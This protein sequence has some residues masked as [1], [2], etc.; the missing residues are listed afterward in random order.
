MAKQTQ[1]EVL[2]KQNGRWEI[3][4]QYA[5]SEED[6]AIMEAKSL[7]GLK[8]VEDVKVIR[9]FFDSNEGTS[10]EYNVY[11]PGKKKYRPPHKFPK[12]SLKNKKNS[13][14]KIFFE[15]KRK[16]RSLHY[17]LMNI[18]VICICSVFIVAT[19]SWFVSRHIVETFESILK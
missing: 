15:T 10:R 8:H 6:E 2:T 18:I 1:Y 16:G 5:E 17:T 11:Q 9:E 13:H 3:N 7:E 12:K 14:K 19:I 4:S